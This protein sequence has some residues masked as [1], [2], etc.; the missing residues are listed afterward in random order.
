MWQILKASFGKR[1]DKIKC[2]SGLRCS[3]LNL[4]ECIG[5]SLIYSLI[6][7]LS[8]PLCDISDC[9]VDCHDI[10]EVCDRNSQSVDRILGHLKV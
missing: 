4:I 5:L 1:F 8:T 9:R 2:G 3:E 10:T 6:L 7:S